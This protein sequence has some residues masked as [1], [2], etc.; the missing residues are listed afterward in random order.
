MEV[1]E[2]IQQ[3]LDALME[4]FHHQL[5]SRLQQIEKELSLARENSDIDSMKNF[6]F[7]V[8]KLAGSAATFGQGSLSVK[9]RE[10]EAYLDNFIENTLLPRENEWAKIQWYTDYL[11]GDIEEV[12][13]VEELQEVDDATGLIDNFQSY[14]AESFENTL[15]F[16]GIDSE[17]DKDIKEELRSFGYTVETVIT[18]SKL[19]E[20]LDAEQS[21][22]LF[23]HT[24][25]FFRDPLLEETLSNL[26]RRNSEAFHL[27][28]LADED[29]F[30]LRLKTVRAGGDAFFVLPADIGRLT[31][32]VE[33]VL[34]RASS[35]PYHVMIVDDDQEQVAYYALVLQQAGMITSVAT[36]PKQVLSILVESKPDLIL[37]DI[38]MKGCNGMELTQLL[39][40]HEAYTTIPVVFLTFDSS[41]E[42]RLQ[43]IG[44]GGDDY[45]TKPIKAD[46]LISVVRMRAERYRELRY[47]MEHDSLTGLL[48]HSN[49]K[50]QLKREVIRCERTGTPLSFAMIDADHFK[51]VNDT[52]GH[53]T[54]DRVLK[55]LARLLQ[56]RLRRT[57]II[58]RY[59][60]EEFGIILLNTG[61]EKAVSIMN[62]IRETFAC[63]SH[64][65]GKQVFHV[66]FSCG[67]SS[68]PECMDA[69]E[70]GNAA[71]EA[72]YA[73]KEAG[74]NQV[75]NLS[76]QCG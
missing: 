36:N 67:V 33:S 8:H 55:S 3:R 34:T 4:E 26:K 42:R 56:D 21:Q 62:E 44:Q 27:I 23:I 1:L 17:A 24:A 30:D 6:R 31:D 63:V 39:R 19:D 37:M 7:M 48:N 25:Q 72:L 70:L 22:I 32:Q 18:R 51:D 53:L 11:R 74:R 20:M 35:C 41:S 46:N 65:A 66:T 12:A 13:E 49:L 68:F 47:H 10:F 57:D 69:G 38:Y 15:Y 5:P 2:S 40:Q 59:G 14:S 43:A 75:V 45:L 60:G 61:A 28:F 71:D 76:D 58:G 64:T 29:N 9:A 16:Y 54:G 73:A 50:E 52:Y